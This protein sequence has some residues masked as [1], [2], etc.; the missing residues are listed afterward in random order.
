MIASC[1][2][3]S[4]QSVI[5]HEEQ[6]GHLTPNDATAIRNDINAGMASRANIEY[7]FS[8]LQAETDIV[9]WKSHLSRSTSI[10]EC[11][12]SGGTIVIDVDSM[13]KKTQLSMITSD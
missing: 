6:A 7:F 12:K 11:I 1:P 13:N 4:I 9:A 8:Q 2:H 5:I 3:N 10:Q